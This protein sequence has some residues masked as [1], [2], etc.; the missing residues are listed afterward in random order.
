MRLVASRPVACCLETGW[1]AGLWEEVNTAIVEATE[2]VMAGIFIIQG[3]DNIGFFA[4]VS[5][6]FFCFMLEAYWQYI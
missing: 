6:G 4:N 2:S 3:F 1:E 5:A